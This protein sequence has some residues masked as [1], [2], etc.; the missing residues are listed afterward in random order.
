MLID[1]RLSIKG[2]KHSAG[3]VILSQNDLFYSKFYTLSK[4]YTFYT[5][6]GGL[7]IWG[8]PLLALPLAHPIRLIYWSG[9]A[10]GTTRT[11]ISPTPSRA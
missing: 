10:V 3:F 6:G 8:W 1:D 5:L 7:G 2:P 4:F 9:W 11:L